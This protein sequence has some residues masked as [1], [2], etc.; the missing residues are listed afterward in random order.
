MSL[1]PHLGGLSGVALWLFNSLT[2]GITGESNCM[3][4]TTALRTNQREEAPALY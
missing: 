2:A 1:S 3:R 4:R